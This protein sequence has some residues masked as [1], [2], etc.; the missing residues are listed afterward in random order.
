MR[1]IAM[2]NA[3][4]SPRC[5]QAWRWIARSLILICGVGATRPAQSAETSAPTF[6]TADRDYWLWQPIKRP[7]IPEAT[8]T[9][10][11]I[12]AH[13]VDAFL[14]APAASADGARRPESDRRTLIRRATFDLHGLPPT[15]QEVDDFVADQSP[16]AFERVIDRL[17]AS[18]R[19]GEHWARHWL[20][21]V[22]YA[23]SDGFK[24][25]DLRPNA[26][27]YRDYVIRAFNEDKPYDRFV[28][29]QL[30]GDE[31]APDDLDARVATGFLRL[32]PYEENARDVLDQR[33]NVLNDITDVTGQVFLGLTFACARCHDH[34]YD[35]ILQADYF[36]LQAFF[37][38]LSQ[39]DEQPLATAAAQSDY[40]ERLR[41]WEDA[42]SESRARLAEIEAPYRAKMRA[43][44]RSVFPDYVQTM[45]D[46]PAGQRT[47][48]E[49]QMAELAERQLTLAPEDVLKKMKPADRDFAK[50]LNQAIAQ[51]GVARPE[52]LPTG[53]I[54][55]DAGPIAPETRIPNEESPIAPGYLTILD[56][57]PATVEAKIETSSGR[58]LALA[59]WI[60]SAENPIASRVM[61]NRVFQQHFG[62]GIVATSEDFGRLG[63]TPSDAQLLD[64]LSS[65][66]IAGGFRLKALHRLLMTSA[67]YRQSSRPVVAGIDAGSAPQNVPARKPWWQISKRR[68]TAEQLRDA[69]LAAS[70]ELNL[71]MGGP[72]IRGDLPKGISEAYAW[73]PDPDEAKR[74]R[75]SIYMLSR[76]NLSD[77]LVNAFDLPDSHESC[78]RRQE[79]TTA[80]QALM[81]LNGR[82]S[83]DR[84]RALA[85]R[86]LQSSA[87]D[88]SRVIPAAYLAAFQREPTAAERAAAEAFLKDQS[89]VVAKRL[90]TPSDKPAV[91]ALPKDA[92]EAE[93]D[94][95]WLAAV[96]DFCHVL[97]N[98]NEFL[99]LD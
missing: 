60:A 18:P 55:R 52:A 68:L 15:P 94:R 63:A 79:T 90:A 41:Q 13:P 80:P 85:G 35:P 92:S 27:R 96:V 61:V 45:L 23:E 72:S 7:Q 84:A 69:M 91:V 10:T 26:W 29:E 12:G 50:E 22:R 97:L 16:Q 9:A 49:R 88:R 43:E 74:N 57:R 24:S 54:A 2:Q 62:R 32:G 31:L 34:K 14:M 37:A 66:F 70:G 1:Q 95:A 87:G 40:A 36:R 86:V 51:C 77:P 11:P 93:T 38:A 47:P 48:L 67:V 73:K 82:W 71:E 19:Y 17:L 20:D 6:S 42:T 99:Y 56:P 21:L 4:K 75:R 30:A 39:E 44:K 98:S 53:M 5:R 78:S 46:T 83:L 64:Y 33:S 81:L 65:E 28:M 58:R 3:E 89:A 8:S 25:D 59:R 76:R